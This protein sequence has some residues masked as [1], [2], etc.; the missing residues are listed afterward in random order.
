[1]QGGAVGCAVERGGASVLRIR[2]FVQFVVF[3]TFCDGAWTPRFGKLLT[4]LVT[5]VGISKGS[6]E[7]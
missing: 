5:F 2:D 3:V 1:M 4:S 7:S 6:R